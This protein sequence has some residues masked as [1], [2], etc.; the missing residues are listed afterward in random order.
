MASLASLGLGWIGEP[1]LAALLDPLFRGVPVPVNV[2]AAHSAAFV[3]AFAIITSVHIAIGEQVPKI[4]AL[5]NAER[6]ALYT[7]A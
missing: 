3:L 1:A 4:V 5:Q 6:T 2:V 7:T